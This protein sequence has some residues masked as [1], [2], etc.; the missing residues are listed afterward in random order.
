MGSLPAAP[1]TLLTLPQALVICHN[2][3]LASKCDLRNILVS[4]HGIL[5]FGTPHSG[6]EATTL[7][8]AINRLASIYMKTTDVVLKDLHAHSSEL[9]NIQ[10]LYVAASEKINSIFLC[11]E[12]A[13]SGVMEREQVRIIS[14]KVQPLIGL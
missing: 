7:L 8:T 5:F 12:Y 2:Q 4:T 1:K 14:Y 6:L 13:N 11:E 10:S 9:E 3:S